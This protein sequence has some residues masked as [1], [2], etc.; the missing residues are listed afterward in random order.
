[1]CRFDFLERGNPNR[2]PLF[3]YISCV[4]SMHHRGYLFVHGCISIHLMCRFDILG[5]AL[6]GGIIKIS[7]HLMCRFDVIYPPC[8]VIST[9]FQYISC[10]GSMLYTRLVWLSLP[11]FNTSHVSVR[12][13][14]AGKIKSL[15]TFQYISCVGSMLSRNART[16]TTTYFNTSHVSV[17]STFLLLFNMVCYISIHL[18]CRF[19]WIPGK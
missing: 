4:G 3:Q 5:F 14:V 7:I 15:I 10:V 6:L 13:G 11:Y 8:V 1:M 12:Y 2:H 18:M 17:R 9:V 19:D 16:A